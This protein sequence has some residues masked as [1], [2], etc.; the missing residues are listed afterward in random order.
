MRHMVTIV[1]GSCVSVCLWNCIL[2]R[3][4]INHYMLL[5]WNGDGLASPE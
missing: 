2:N 3:G 4:G 5:F 1:L